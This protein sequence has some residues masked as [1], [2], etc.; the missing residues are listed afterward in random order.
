MSLRQRI[1]ETARSHHY[2]AALING[3]DMLWAINA[4]PPE[5]PTVL[6]AHNLEHQVLVQQLANSRFFS[7]IF[8]REI[9]K[10]RRYEIE[11]FRRAR[12]VIFLSTTEMAWGCAQVP[13]LQALHVP[14]LFTEPPIPS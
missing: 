11:G 3:S 1:R 12:G 13:G 5:M 7:R 4:L 2:D 14:P 10:Q 9:T 8:K 6:I